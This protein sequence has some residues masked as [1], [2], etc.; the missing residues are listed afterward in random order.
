M[1]LVGNARLSQV[2]LNRLGEVRL[3]VQS[4]YKTEVGANAKV[5][6]SLSKLK[7]PN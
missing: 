3:A 5:P 6:P 7:V 4:Q 2:I 1:V